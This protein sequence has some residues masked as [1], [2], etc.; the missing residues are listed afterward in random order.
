MNTN[1]TFYTKVIIEN[2]PATRKDSFVH[3]TRQNTVP[4]PDLTKG[5]GSKA[6]TNRN[7]DNIY[8]LTQLT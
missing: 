8:G 5:R 6:S 4:T 3:S 2:A 7:Y 1:D